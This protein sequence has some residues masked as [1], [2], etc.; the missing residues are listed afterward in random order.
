MRSHIARYKRQIRTIRVKATDGDSGRETV[1][2]GNYFRCWHCG[3]ICDV[4]R[5]DLSKEGRR[6][7]VL[8]RYPPDPQKSNLDVFADE[9]S[10]YWA[11]EGDTAWYKGPVADV[12]RVA[13]GDTLLS[14]NVGDT[15]HL[16]PGVG[17]GIVL[18]K[19][20]AGGEYATI[21]QVYT[22]SGGGCPLCHTAV[23]KKP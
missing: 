21:Y 7:T 4:R 14:H 5:D 2:K 6:A 10:T 1:D 11:D 8:K 16:N 19:V 22:V 9:G 17:H 15:V 23:W 13:P 20:L 12:H 18:M 3:F